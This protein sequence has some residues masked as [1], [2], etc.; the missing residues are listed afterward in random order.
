MRFNRAIFLTGLVS[1]LY[2]IAFAVVFWLL[3]PAHAYLTSGHFR[4][5]EITGLLALTHG[6]RVVATWLFR[7]RAILFLVPGVATEVAVLGAYYPLTNGDLGL[8]TL[9]FTSSSFI[10]FECLRALGWNV[11]AY[12]GRQPNWRWVMMAGVL[13]AFV[14]AAIC[15]QLDP[16]SSRPDVSVWRSVNAVIGGTTGLFVWLL[17]LRAA[18]RVWARA[19]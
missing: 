13:A 10:A 1:T 19:L 5:A 18:L 15:A 16:G 6:V 11:Y 3:I 8:L 14:S 12:G 9:A 2:L 7:W 4:F 17:L